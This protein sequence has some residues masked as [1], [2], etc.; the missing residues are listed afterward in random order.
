[1][2]VWDVGKWKEVDYVRGGS[3]GGAAPLSKVLL[4]LRIMFV[5]GGGIGGGGNPAENRG[6][7][8][9]GPYLSRCN[10]SFTIMENQF[11]FSKLV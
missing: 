11:Q 2:V 10:N 7:Q 3:G 9:R 1:M 8:G 6:C 5:E 4:Q